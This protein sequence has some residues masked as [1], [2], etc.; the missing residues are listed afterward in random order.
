MWFDTHCHLDPDAFDGDAGVDAAVARAREAGVTRM[1]TIG[2]GY[3]ADTM[4]RAR[5]VASRHGDVWFSAGVHPHDAKHWGPDA[6]ARI[7]GYA[8]HPKCVAVGE[9][10]LD[11]HY[12]MSPRDEQRACFR[13]QIRLA[14]A[15]GKPI[16][17]HD[18]DS[19]GETLAILDDEGAFEGRVLYHCYSSGVEH[20]REITDRGGFI[21]IPGIV[22]FK[23]ADEMKAVAADVPD[24]LLLVETDAPFLTP[25]PFRGKRNEP[26]R[27]IHTGAFVAELRGLSPEAL[28]ALTMANGNRFYGLVTD[29]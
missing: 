1:V 10:G 29:A 12:D 7:E 14:K 23:K 28:A 26:A 9:M 16:I 19:D 22:T 21:S 8:A 2:A 15:L 13:E 18:R 24:H 17:I 5:D 11:F 27:V 20:M 6:K 4:D 25:V 3:G